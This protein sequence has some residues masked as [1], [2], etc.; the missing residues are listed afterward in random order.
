MA[1]TDAG[2]SSLALA[3]YS[4]N[5]YYSTFFNGS[6]D[7]LSVP[8]NA[9][10]QLTGVF[11]IEAY[12]YF[13][14]APTTQQ[15]WLSKGPST[16]STGSWSI[17][18]VGSGSSITRLYYDTSGT[19]ITFNTSLSINTWY[20]IAVVRDNSNVISCYI[21]GVKEAT[22]A[23]VTT[24]FTDSS[25]VRVGVSRGGSAPWFNGYLSNVRILK[26]TALYTANFNAPTTQL[27]AITN[28]QLLT[29]NT[30]GFADGSVNNFTITNNG[31]VGF[32]QFTP[33]LQ[34]NASVTLSP[35][36]STGTTSYTFS[37]P[38][39][40]Q[41]ISV[42]P[43]AVDPA[44]ATIKYNSNVTLTSGQSNIASTS[45]AY[46]SGYSANFVSGILQY[47]NSAPINTNGYSWTVEFWLYPTGNYANYNT[48]FT[49]RVSASATTAYQ[50][51]LAITTGYISFYNGT[52]YVSSYTLTPNVWSHV[53]Y[54][55]DG[56]QLSIYVNGN[57]VYGVVVTITDNTEPLIIGGVRGF[58]Q[59]TIGNIS[60]FRMVKGYQIYTGNFIPPTSPLG[61]TQSSG[62]GI[63]A[64][65]GAPTNG[66]S[67]YFN[68]T[69]AYLTVPSNA[70][71]AYGT[72]DFT[73]EFWVYPTNFTGLQVIF[74]QRS[75]TT[76]S[77]TP[78][79]YI[80]SGTLSYYV[81]GADRIVGASLSILT[82]SHIAV[83]RSGTST[84][85]F[86]NGGQTG[87]TYSDATS[88]ITSPVRIAGGYDATANLYAF[89]GYLSNVRA[90][91][92]TALYT[93]NFAPSAAPLTAIANTSL[94][95][96]Q[97][98]LTNDAST[99]NFTLTN[100]NATLY[101]AASP[102]NSVTSAI[103]PNGSSVYFNGSTNLTGS[104]DFTATGNFTIECWIYPTVTTECDILKIGNEA[105]GRIVFG[106]GLPSAGNLSYNIYGSNSVVLATNIAINTWQHV[107]I[108]RTGT[109]ITGYVN[110]V[111]GTPV[112]GVI[113]TLGN[114]SGFSIM[115]TGTGYISNLRY[116]N[117]TA[118]YGSNFTV[119]TS[120]LV[121]VPNTKLLALQSSVTADASSNNYTL[122]ASSPAPTLSTTVSPFIT[123]GIAS[124][125]FLSTALAYQQV[126]N[127]YVPALSL[128]QGHNNFTAE[129]WVYLTATPPTAPGW[130]IM[131]KG[132]NSTPGLE[133]SFSVTSTGLYFQTTS[134]IPTGTTT[135]TSFTA[136]VIP[137]QWM[138]LALTKVGTSVNI[139][140]NGIYTGT[141]NGVNNLFYS[142][143]VASYITI[144]NTQTGATTAFSG[145][146]NN[147]RVVYGKALY[148]VNYDTQF[149]PP[150]TVSL[151]QSATSTI[152][153]IDNASS[154]TTVNGSSVYF[155]NT[156]DFLT[157]PEPAS[158]FYSA[159]FNGSNQYISTPNTA[160]LNLGTGDF[161]IEFWFNILSDSA[162]G[163][164]TFRN[165]T[166]LSMLNSTGQL[167]GWG[168][169]I[170]GDTST[171]GTSG[172]GL[173]NYVNDTGTSVGRSLT[174]LSKNR[175]Y[176]FALSCT[177][178]TSKLFMDGVLADTQT[179]AQNLT[180]ANALW[181]GASAQTS[182]QRFF[183]GFISNLRI[184]KG[185][186]LY[187]SAFTPSTIP[188]TRTSQGATA[189][190]V[191]F[192]SLQNS[193]IVDNSSS[194]LTITNVGT[195][196]TSQN[197][198]FQLYG[199]GTNVTV[200]AWV[201]LGAAPTTRGW[202]INNSATT[203]GYF[204]V[205]IEAA[206]TI[207]VWSDSNVTAVVTSATLIPLGTWTH[208]A[209]TYVNQLLVIYINGVRDT[210]TIGKS[211][212]W[213]AATLGTVYIGRQASAAAQY[214]PGYIT[215]LRM[216]YGLA[217]YTSKFTVPS[218]PLTAI[219]TT[220]F[221]GLQSSVT[222]DGSI[223]NATITKGS[224]ATGLILSPLTSPFTTYLPTVANG[225][226]I[227]FGWG[228]GAS[229]T[230]YLTIAT[231]YTTSTQL[232]GDFTIES[233]IYMGAMPSA[234][235][236]IID[237]RS[238]A[239]D[240]G[241]IFYVLNTGVLRFDSSNAAVLTGTT[242][243]SPNTWYH[244][245]VVRQNTLL[246]FFINGTPESTTATVNTDYGVRSVSTVSFGRS[247]AP[248][249]WNGYLSNFRMVIGTAIYTGPFTPS[250]TPFS[251]TTSASTNTVA[252]T[253]ITTYP[254]TTSSTGL[255]YS[256][257][258]YFGGGGTSYLSLPNS[259]RF[260]LDALD[261]TIEAWIY[262]TSTTYG[263]NKTIVGYG[264]L[265]TLTDFAF[266]FYQIRNNS[267]LATFVF[268]PVT[269]FNSGGAVPT[270]S[271]PSVTFYPNRWYHIAVTRSGA[272]MGFYLNGVSIGA[273][274]GGSLT[275]GQ[276]I[277]ATTS[278]LTIGSYGGGGGSYTG[279]ISNVRMY[280][281]YAI[282]NGSFTPPTNYITNYHTTTSS[283][284]V[285][286]SGT[287]TSLLLFQNSTSTD[288]SS[289]NFT[290][291][292]TGSLSLS[293]TVQPFP[294]VTNGLSV[295]FST[296]IGAS[297]NSYYLRLYTGSSTYV[298]GTGDF[299]IEFYFNGSSQT[300]RVI[301]D[302]RD[303]T[304]NAQ[305]Y[306][307]IINSRLNWGPTNL[308]GS[309]VIANDLWNHCAIVR[310]SGTVYIYVNGVLDNSGADTTDYSATSTYTYVGHSS[311]NLNSNFITG[312]LSNLRAVKGVSVYTGTFTVPTSPLTST[313]S[314]STN[315]S[316][317]TGTQTLY[318]T[319][320]TNPIADASTNNV[321]V[322]TS[323]SGTTASSPFVAINGKSVFF[324]G[325]GNYI[326]IPSDAAFNFGTGDFTIEC[327][328]YLSSGTT[329][330][331]IFD[332]RTS[333]TSV[334]PVLYITSNII[335][336]SVAG[337]DVI[338]GSTL[339]VTT[340]YHIALS[341]I[342]GNTK[343]YVNGA[344]VGS[345]YVDSN[346]YLVGAPSI[347]T[348]FGSS[349]SLTGYLT[350][351]RVVKG[352]GVYTASFTTPTTPLTTT[353]SSNNLGSVALFSNP[354]P[355]LGNSVYFNGV[356]D[357]MKVPGITT[358]MGT[359][360]F[361]IETYYYPTSF[362]AVT[363]LLGQ[364]TAATTGLGYWNI[365]VTTAGIITVY[366]NGST[367]FTASTAI[368]INEWVH[369]ALVRISGTITLY[370]NGVS[371][372]TVSYAT[373]F[374]LTSVASPIHIG[375]TQAPAA[376]AVGYM[377]NLRI[378]KGLGVYTG[379]FT[380]PTSPLSST[381]SSG[382]NIAAITGTS[383]SLLLYQ[384]SP[385]TDNST[386]T[387]I[388]TPFGNPQY[389]PVFS[390]SFFTYPTPAN[391]NSGYF[392]GTT[393]FLSLTQPS[394]AGTGNFTIELW[395]YPTSTAAPG[396]LLS[397]STTGA[398]C[399]HLGI[400]A[401]AQVTFYVDQ[402]S[403]PN[404]TSTTP[405]LAKVYTWTHIA[406]NRVGGVISLYVNG[407]QQSTTL[408]KAT[409]FGDTGTLNIGRYQVSGNQYFSGY[410][411]NVRFVYGSN[412]YS[413]SYFTPPYSTPLT[414]ITNTTLLLLQTTLTKDNSTNNVTITNTNTVL[415]TYTNPYTMMKLPVLLTGQSSR[416]NTSTTGIRDNSA[417]NSTVTSNTLNFASYQS[418]V[419]PF[420]V[421][422]TLLLGQNS[423]TRDDSINN[424][425]LTPSSAPNIFRYVTPFNTNSVMFQGNTTGNAGV[426]ITGTSLYNAL[427]NNFTIEFFIMA[428]PQNASIG[429]LILGKNAAY[430]TVA[431]NNYYIMCSAPGGFGRNQ[432][433]TLQIHSAVVSTSR[434]VYISATPLCNSK[435][436]H[437]AIVRINN[438][439]T[440]YIDG[441]V[442]TGG[443][444]YTNNFTDSNTWDYSTYTMGSNANDGTY[445]VANLAFA[446]L[447]SNL[448]IINGTGIYTGAF[449][450]PTSTISR[451]VSSGTNISSYTPTSPSN[452][453][454]SVRTPTTTD[455]GLRI[456]NPIGCNIHLN[457]YTFEL[458]HYLVNRQTTSPTL[459]TNV[460]TFQAG[461]IA[462]YAG[463]S[464]A[465]TSK[466]QLAF[467]GLSFSTS[468]WLQSTSDI[469]YNKWTH[470]A[471][472]RKS[473]TT[474]LYINGILDSSSPNGNYNIFSDSGFG[475]GGISGGA[476]I[477]FVSNFRLVVGVGVYS[478]TNTI[479]SNFTVPNSGLQLTQTSS[480]NIAAITNSI[481]TNMGA[482]QSTN[483]SY[484]YSI[485]NSTLLLDGNTSDFTI[486]SYIY[487][488]TM[489]TTNSWTTGTVVLFGT[490]GNPSTG[491]HFVI[492]STELFIVI[493]NTKYGFRTSH[494]M[495]AFNWYH[496][497][498]V[499]IS[500]I[501]YFYVNGVQLGSVGVPANAAYVSNNISGL[502]STASYQLTGYLS[503][504]R[505]VIGSGIY[506]N[507][508]PNLLL[509][510]PTV[511]PTT[512]DGTIT[513]SSV[514][515][516]SVSLLTFQN[517]Y[518]DN[519]LNNFSLT[520][521]STSLVTV[522]S[523]F[524]GLNLFA[525]SVYFS[526][527]DYITTSSYAW[528]FYTGTFT[529]EFYVYFITMP[530]SGNL[531]R[532]LMFGSNGD[533]GSYFVKFDN[534]GVI[535]TGVQQ[536]GYTSI[537]TP[538]N[539]FTTNTWYH[540]AI[541][542][543]NGL[544]SIYVNGVSL[545]GPS[546]VTP[547]SNSTV[548]LNIGY[549][550]Q[551]IQFESGVFNGYLSNLRVTR[552]TA[553][554]TGAFTV[555]TNPLTVTQNSSTNIR[556]LVN[557]STLPSNAYSYTGFT[558]A[559][560]LS[561]ATNSNFAMGT[562]NFTIECWFYSTSISTGQSIIDL[563]S[564]T[565][566]ANIGFALYL[567]TS[568]NVRF[569]TNGSN[570]VV[571]S[572][573][574]VSNRWYH[575]AVVRTS[576][577]A[578]SM[579]LN[580]V[581]ESTTFTASATQNF[582]NSTP[583]IGFG[584]DGA[585]S[586][587]ISNLRVIKGQALYTGAFTV[588]TSGL[589]N[590]TVGTSGANVA[591]SITGT[592]SLL[593][594][595]NS[596]II[597]SSGNSLTITNNLGTTG[598][599]NVSNSFSPFI[600]TV[601]LLTCQQSVVVD[602]GVN[603]FVVSPT[604][605][606]YSVTNL[607]PFNKTVQAVS[608]TTPTTNVTAPSNAAFTFGT[609]DFTIEAWI[610]LS[611]GTTGTIFD[612]RSSANSVH[613][614][615]Y[616]SGTVKYRVAGVDV[617]VGQTISTT[618]W[619]HIALSR[620]SGITKLFVD[621]VQTGSSY[622]DTNNYLIGSPN[623][624]TGINSFSPLVGYLYNLRVVKGVGVYSNTFPRITSLLSTSQSSTTTISKIS[625]TIPSNGGSLGLFANT[626]TG[627]YGPGYF[628]PYTSTFNIN[629]VDFTLELWCYLTV[630]SSSQAIFSYYYQSSSVASDG[631]FSVY[632]SGTSWV[633]NRS[634]ADASP[635]TIT[636]DS[637]NNGYFN[638]VHHAFV[639]IG[640]GNY[641]FINGICV[642]YSSTNVWIFTRIPYTLTLGNILPGSTM[643][644]NGFIS[645]CRLVYGIGVYT[646]NFSVPTSPLALTQSSGTNI[647]SVPAPTVYSTG[648]GW[649][650]AA[651]V[652]ITYANNAAF[653]LGTGDFTIEWY[654][655]NHSF[656]PN[657]TDVISTGTTTNT[658]F[659]I[660]HLA[661]G[662]YLFE[663]GSRTTQFI[664]SGSNGVTVGW[665]H[666]AF[667]RSGTSTI[668]FFRNGLLISTGTM[669][670][671]QNF[672]GTNGQLINNN[673]AWY[674]SNFR[675]VKGQALYSTTFT[676]STT[677]LTTTSQGATASNVSLLTFQNGPTLADNGTNNF[678][679]TYPASV[680]GSPVNR[681]FG[682][683][684]TLMLLA[685]NGLVDNGPYYVQPQ[686]TAN[687]VYT[688]AI[689]PFT[690]VNNSVTAL[691]TAQSNIS[692]E[693]SGLYNY[694]L[695]IN[696]SA[697][698]RFQRTQTPIGVQVPT[699]LL[700]SQSNT[701]VDNGPY[702]SLHTISGQGANTSV[703][704]IYGPFITSPEPAL[705]SI[706]SGV[707]NDATNNKEKMTIAGGSLVSPTDMSPF[708]TSK[709]LTSLLVPYGYN[710]LSINNTVGSGYVA[711]NA[712][713]A[714]TNFT[715]NPATI[716]STLV[717]VLALQSSNI[718]IDNSINN[719]VFTTANTA[720]TSSTLSPFGTYYA[721]GILILNTNSTTGIYGS[722]IINYANLLVTAGDAVTTN[723]YSITVTSLNNV[724]NIGNRT[725]LDTGLIPAQSNANVSL[726]DIGNSQL[727]E[728][729]ILTFANTTITPTTNII[730]YGISVA[731]SNTTFIITD[732][733]NSNLSETLSNIFV[734]NVGITKIYIDSG[735]GQV[736]PSNTTFFISDVANSNISETIAN[737]TV[738]NVSTTR[739][740][741]DTGT[742]PP[743]SPVGGTILFPTYAY[744]DGVTITAANV[745]GG[746]SSGSSTASNQQIW[747]QT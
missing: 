532:F 259:G 292:V 43:T 147:A 30:N 622:T 383:T 217:V 99:N 547:P 456:T 136:N 307:N 126:S 183:N 714:Q 698:I 504:F 463:H 125:T 377:S 402:A 365:Q 666:M 254:T 510:T 132:V 293:S 237:T 550:T 387:N 41:A 60:N 148:T 518:T 648:L 454:Y 461:G 421:T 389:S 220:V 732:V 740:I 679:I 225:N 654:V 289:N 539:S 109:I 207:T 154:Y 513:I 63:R 540:M 730:D 90:V 408:S 587:Y 299:T 485:N 357:Y 462:L 169:I 423:L 429:A 488:L 444:G 665:D 696:P 541:V 521:N 199:D 140:F 412:V 688:S 97:N 19:G 208:I 712:N 211:T 353:Q 395:V 28:T 391:A 424:Y 427:S 314:S 323:I 615:L 114:T 27:T 291:T 88:Y 404:I 21:N 743:P 702:S 137:G 103:Q 339:S 417:Y 5:T 92:G 495:S 346:N 270:I 658:S 31:S 143:S 646:G 699:V 385:F 409:Q 573:T 180:N 710:D 481:T 632:N 441:A 37:A 246:R 72:G 209:V 325:S 545:V 186:G 102:F 257:S 345:T 44:L 141:V 313:Q 8:D 410:I 129:A 459:V 635:V 206:R 319:L 588:P 181:I 704:T 213:Q 101:T 12:V 117:G 123:T 446:G 661:N 336:Y 631:G 445:T 91:K 557:S 263:S 659:K 362:D 670:S 580:G 482:V 726:V 52:E 432:L 59:W 651:N 492:G 261:F 56:N 280:R 331:T 624:G 737:V 315:I 242:A 390:P 67:G 680:I 571:G 161:T 616:V 354:I 746:G 76:T 369:I 311:R 338:T 305:P 275:V 526:G 690:D 15:V 678:T 745:Q 81:N 249:Y 321:S 451:T 334:H 483:F 266:N 568:S 245:A 520:N 681:P 174:T 45:P 197:H 366:Y 419:S 2:L 392:N 538:S 178:G 674:I 17:G 100:N 24:S 596:T 605:G 694:T 243:L 721:N 23:T 167:N 611:S 119:Y 464:T 458:Y 515:A 29:C 316:A 418:A 39:N 301:L 184:V 393:S 609:G 82:W 394:N 34:S 171:T 414:A 527:S 687:V 227:G 168:I 368:L 55:Y 332:N 42:T 576:T 269:G 84:K 638:W 537:S 555:P 431:N 344:Q 722:N 333:S 25:I 221:L 517:S 26:G 531:V 644:L 558:F 731:P 244:I 33:L 552:D 216:V 612:S 113:G 642:W 525:S 151:T 697:G 447:L 735:L 222:L 581:Q 707:V 107:A 470:I 78:T 569:G 115:T 563:R 705:L 647:S 400:N 425:T 437:V 717:S 14:T 144:A 367:N 598:F 40:V 398:N 195:T 623:F 229:P 347:G 592:V 164:D 608:F 662:S 57:K 7:Y 469:I 655:Y 643:A 728:A 251:L 32:K 640:T 252:T 271:S 20:H 599:V 279:Y 602:N 219:D 500:N 507:T 236:S 80:N 562:G 590:S 118:V 480:S 494:G 65:T 239:T 128:G 203:T 388:I 49:K 340:W 273:S 584:A 715:Y 617:I 685:Q 512:Q 382:T 381:Q 295:F 74:E 506:K 530:P 231:G 342:S 89:Y 434:A 172:V 253:S 165:A 566:T 310:Q 649:N 182:Y 234:G 157:F 479:T 553:I 491:T 122:T 303:E 58:T 235:A 529:I 610:Y 166:L 542:C 134:G 484:G 428:G 426:Y 287:Q 407:V 709:S 152:S 188:L 268:Y 613:P 668:R 498:Y 187:S 711:N 629:S 733:A 380:V 98:S 116:V 70:A 554:Y 322:I 329:S 645:N 502:T 358:S 79:I 641:W 160:A 142:T 653:A 233:W 106:V 372:G 669:S 693:S 309:V 683:N 274:S 77:A 189:S 582:T 559:S 93:T 283:S 302:K 460:G 556:S 155:N 205:A 468:N 191:S 496:V 682:N 159:Q 442:D 677:P 348:G 473:G 248:A 286:I 320:Q 149:T 523:P 87:S 71:F 363:T 68:G 577:T 561:L 744:T 433:Q 162:A 265:S 192:L 296:I 238:V 719:G 349:N 686:S 370:V 46:T 359:G 664:Q 438:V 4:T 501:V 224:G 601:T 549:H 399:F 667:V 297:P 177:S 701:I 676:P 524:N 443:L 725:T 671:T 146:I 604:S 373:Q 511:L 499:K 264:N 626:A 505:L 327:W 597:D 415:S 111:A 306:I 477:G 38:A 475:I 53:A 652:T 455:Y 83:S 278:V 156:N 298:F 727:N 13:V 201:M 54:T 396:L 594:C 585:F 536:G 10:L 276:M 706:Q 570:Y 493:S 465:N 360:D 133:W 212:V 634:Y 435:W 603:N 285:A 364:Y 503:N 250:L 401:S 121:A 724:G 66:Y 729:T 190:Q 453:G 543:S 684:G 356:N 196:P 593:T 62:T 691:L 108:V 440:V 703:S 486:E 120:P 230:D 138:H 375:V 497:A 522:N 533:G 240:E 50:G 135:S 564:P 379:A 300:N 548:G 214:F 546:T 150:T 277:S 272:T 281:G 528:G 335:T 741:A 255:T 73:I 716:P 614:V 689:S 630:K 194:A 193:T 471:V 282:Y 256:G 416:D 739:S 94:L 258:V 660:R 656:L 64:I 449:T 403:V 51:Y 61:L 361:T 621:G 508:F 351:L 312:Y 620:I 384:N 304:T 452:L 376:Y 534:S 450:V 139:W 627:T 606:I 241:Y 337:V 535:S 700:T 378:V 467:N 153:S 112:T 560:Y 430:A 69:S 22:T 544:G 411:T 202:I 131:Q 176:H 105:T 695:S 228:S 583:R 355:S 579:Y 734:S 474:Y 514:S 490:S 618:T 35:T 226:S 308:Q 439:I 198:P 86:I 284:I 413:G 262:D 158:N 374:G 324:N 567:G 223:N 657:D 476:V 288:A 742:Q 341:K 127:P 633:L 330:G 713:V 350:N 326:I 210:N 723:S 422:P 405:S 328:V 516:S 675:I 551:G 639:R 607:S 47:A 673:G 6:T 260:Y 215:N 352:V 636:H 36:F 625:P 11:T 589:T 290:S 317:I 343:L 145:F 16:P 487:F 572:T 175:W 185:T 294:T 386:Y 110:G 1:A 650:I 575:V 489:P 406:I 371:Y 9:A 637:T 170:F 509:P 448:R 578:I 472:V 478:G 436:H 595:Q 619:Y 692:V 318:L 3:T 397:S 672:T 720:P 218:S 586:G 130:Y 574:L 104:A 200:E 96:L 628:V 95:A 466:Y 267:T 747:Y 600:N 738:S 124:T 179:A 519:S 173:Y 663:D 232:P 204:G 420:G 591:A 85:M 18:T 457:D 565:D 75:G 708:S 48:L 247:V 736:A 163:A 718:L